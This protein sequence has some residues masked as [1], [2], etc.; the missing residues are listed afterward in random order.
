MERHTGAGYLIGR[1]PHATAPSNVKIDLLALQVQ[2]RGY[3]PEKPATQ[4]N[5]KNQAKGDQFFYQ[6]KHLS[7]AIGASWVCNG[8]L[9]GAT[10]AI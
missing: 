8:N 7:G 2:R 1:N 9:G 10:C 6:F 4:H 5:D 3:K